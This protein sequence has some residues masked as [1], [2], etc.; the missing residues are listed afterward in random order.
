MDGGAHHFHQHR[1]ITDE[2]S[3]P[4]GCWDP[5]ARHGIPV[6]VFFLMVECL[7]WL[8]YVSL[9]QQELYKNNMFLE[10]PNA[11]LFRS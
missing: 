9:S 1:A 6:A 8:A 7:F 4:E 2:V 10:M 3:P 11:I 5:L